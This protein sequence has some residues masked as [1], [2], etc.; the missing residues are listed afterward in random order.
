MPKMSPQGASRSTN[1]CHLSAGCVSEIRPFP[2]IKP[3]DDSLAVYS[4]FLSKPFM[5]GPANVIFVR[6]ADLADIFQ[7]L[8][9]FI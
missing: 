6:S 1:L 9:F 7:K 5:N 3:V 8:T 4:W 2:Q